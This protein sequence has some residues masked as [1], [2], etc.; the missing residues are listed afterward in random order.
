M[1]HSVQLLFDPTH[2]VQ[3]CIHYLQDKS[4]GS[5]KYPELHLHGCTVCLLGILTQDSQVVE[6]V[7]Q[8]TQGCSQDLH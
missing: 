5:S 2:S 3:G 8:F 4:E 6:V 7:L 1:T